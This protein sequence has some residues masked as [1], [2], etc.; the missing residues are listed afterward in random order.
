MKDYT[1][2]LANKKSENKTKDFEES[3]KNLKKCCYALSKY[4]TYIFRKNINIK[5]YYMIILD[6]EEKSKQKKFSV[7]LKKM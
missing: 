3:Y 6:T 2:I 5:K 4:Y 1:I 7:T